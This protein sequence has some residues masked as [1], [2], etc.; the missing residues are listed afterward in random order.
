M[1]DSA[2][3]LASQRITTENGITYD[4]LKAGSAEAFSGEDYKRTLETKLRNLKF[5]NGMNINLFCNSL[6]TLITE[7]Y[8]LTDLDEASIDAIPTNHVIAQLEKQFRQD[9]KMLQLASSKS[10]ERWLEIV[11]DKLSGNPLFSN[12][13]QVSAAEHSKLDK[14]KSR[15]EK[16]AVKADALSTT[17]KARVACASCGKSNNLE[18]N[19]L[20]LKTCLNVTKKAILLVFA[21]QTMLNTRQRH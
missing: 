7:L 11:N 18:D 5:T 9:T 13:V 3:T 14:M 10:L 4:N 1:E 2:F 17:S 19:C 16:L 21:K 20:I 6:C 15:N 12:Y 8:N